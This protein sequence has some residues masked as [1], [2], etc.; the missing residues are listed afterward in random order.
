MYTYYNRRKDTIENTNEGDKAAK[1]YRSIE[2]SAKQTS[3][4]REIK[5]YFPGYIAELNHA[6]IC[7][8]A[9]RKIQFSWD[10]I[11]LYRISWSRVEMRYMVCRF[12]ICNGISDV[13]A[14]SRFHAFTMLRY[15]YATLVGMKTRSI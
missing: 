11:N 13:L 12:D 10:E 3:R 5:Y 6:C 2:F 14:Y 4:A 8:A 15:N 9:R 1:L 7:C